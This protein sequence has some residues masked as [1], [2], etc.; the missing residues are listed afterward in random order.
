M[1]EMIELKDK[2]LVLIDIIFHQIENG[3]GLQRFDENDL[4]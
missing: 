2:D 1:I 4:I 3:I